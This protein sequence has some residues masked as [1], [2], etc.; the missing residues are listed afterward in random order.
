MFFTQFDFGAPLVTYAAS[1]ANQRVFGLYLGSTNCSEPAT[2]PALYVDVFQF[3]SW[4]ST[5]MAAN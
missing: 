2:Y 1:M 3:K 5:T 4:I